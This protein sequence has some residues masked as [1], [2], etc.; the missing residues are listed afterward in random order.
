MPRL[1]ALALTLIFLACASAPSTALRP[2]MTLSQAMKTMDLRRVPAPQSERETA[3]T[4]VASYMF[5]RY[6][7]HGWSPSCGPAGLIEGVFLEFTNDKLTA[8]SNF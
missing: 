3:G 2:G 7:L 6:T 8:I 5:C 1:A 4:R